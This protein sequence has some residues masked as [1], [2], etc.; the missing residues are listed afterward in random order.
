[1]Q[2]V[3]TIVKPITPVVIASMAHVLVGDRKMKERGFDKRGV[4]IR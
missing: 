4:N 3:T 1:M 2:R